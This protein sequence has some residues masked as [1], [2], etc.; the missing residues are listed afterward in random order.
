MAKDNPVCSGL[1]TG[2]VV[3]TGASESTAVLTETLKEL[4]IGRDEY[5]MGEG[6]RNQFY[7]CLASGF[8]SRSGLLADDKKTASGIDFRRPSK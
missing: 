4:W 6:N 5:V 2:G 1:Y 3:H 7:I 8:G